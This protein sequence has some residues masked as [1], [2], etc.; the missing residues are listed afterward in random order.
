MFSCIKE[1][2]GPLVAVIA[3]RPPTEAPITAARLAI[4]SSIWMMQPPRPGRRRAMVSM[5]SVEGVMG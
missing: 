2:P 4:S 3:L 5:I 1:K